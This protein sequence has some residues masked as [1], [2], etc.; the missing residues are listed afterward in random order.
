M[1]AIGLFDVLLF[2]ASILGL[3]AAWAACR[4]QLQ[5]ADGALSPFIASGQ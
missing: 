1:M 4:D 3:V 5:Q 2:T